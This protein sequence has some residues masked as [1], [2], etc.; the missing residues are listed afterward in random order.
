MKGGKTSE[1]FDKQY[2]TTSGTTTA[3]RATH[4]LHA[5]CLRQNHQLDARQR[6]GRVQVSTSTG[7]PVTAGGLE[8]DA[9]VT[10][11]V[12]RHG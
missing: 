10:G 6:A 8:A 4:Q 3:R 1:Q 11:C 9:P 2:A 7:M 12:R 5:L